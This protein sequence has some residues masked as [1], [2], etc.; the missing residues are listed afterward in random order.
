MFNRTMITAGGAAILVLVMAGSMH[1]WGT[2]AQTTYLTFNAPFALPGTALPP[3]TYI[4][5]LADPINARDV[6]RVLSRDRSRLY[7][8]AFTHR[9][10]RPRGLGDGVSVSFSEVPRGVTPPVRAWYP[11]GVSVGH[12][13]IYSKDSRQL[14]G[15]AGK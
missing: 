9:I 10:E 5:E 7:L 1:A 2:A 13:F 6:V 14:T 12:Q 3:G 15:P 11:I 4:F 8:T